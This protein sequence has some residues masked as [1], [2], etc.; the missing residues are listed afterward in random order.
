MNDT[1]KAAGL[2]ARDGMAALLADY[3]SQDQDRRSQLM[4]VVLGMGAYS[5][6]QL[7]AELWA[8]ADAIR[9]LRSL[10]KGS[11]GPSELVAELA[12]DHPA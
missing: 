4:A 1:I 8:L 7:E 10:P 12:G 3:P 5:A 2:N 11:Y 6:E 9:S